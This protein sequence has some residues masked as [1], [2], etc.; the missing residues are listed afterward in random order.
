MSVLCVL[1]CGCASAIGNACGLVSFDLKVAE[2]RGEVV[3]RELGVSEPGTAHPAPWSVWGPE[4]LG[5]IKGLSWSTLG[6]AHF[7]LNRQTVNISGFV[8]QTQLCKSSRRQ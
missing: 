8:G 6:S 5:I 4:L 2:L 7:S 1:E 3:R